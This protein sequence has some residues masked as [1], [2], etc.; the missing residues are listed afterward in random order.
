M[1]FEKFSDGIIDEKMY[2]E[3]SEIYARKCEDISL[4]IEKHQTE[5]DKLLRGNSSDNEWIRYFKQYRKVASVDRVLLIMLIDRIEVY[6]NNRFK[7]VFK[8][9]DQFNLAK[10]YI[11][12]RMEDKDGK[13]EPS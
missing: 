13:N 1:S 4:A 11:K 9:Q 5:L 3:Y 2:R 10:E 7:V 12:E 6:E 8:Y